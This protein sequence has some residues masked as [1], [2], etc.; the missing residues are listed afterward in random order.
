MI[1]FIGP[2]GQ[3]LLDFV[4]SMDRVDRFFC[5]M[6]DLLHRQD[7]G[8]CFDRGKALCCLNILTGLS[9][10]KILEKLLALNLEIAEETR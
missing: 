6:Q 5:L 4:E 7:R 8:S 9:N 10:E 2:D 1:R 3:K